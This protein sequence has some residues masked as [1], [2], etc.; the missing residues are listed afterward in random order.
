M[1]TFY[2]TSV[3]ALF[4]AL[5]SSL[6]SAQ[7]S[8][9][10]HHND[11]ARTGANL[12]ETALNTSNVNS[13]QFGK[14][15]SYPV[16]GE[17]YTQPLYLPAVTVPGKGV[18]NIVLVA[19]MNDSVYAFDADSN[20]GSN[21][22]PLWFTNF[23]N[24]AAGITPVPAE[25][26]Q[27][28]GNFNIHGPIGILS[29]PVVD[30]STGLVY[31]VARTK[32]NGSYFFRLHALS[33]ASGIEKSFSPVTITATVPGSGY[34][35]VGGMVTFNSFRSNQ[36]TALTLANG[37]VYVSFASLGDIDPYHG[38]LFGYSA[39][40]LQQMSVVNLT[41]NGTRGG[42][43]QSGNGEAVDAAGSV[44]L[45][46]GN[47][48]WDG[49]KNFGTSM[50]KFNPLNLAVADYFTPSDYQNENQ[51]D[52]DLGASGP[53]LIPNTNLIA[54]GGK[55]GILFVAPTG[56][57]GHLQS[58]KTTQVQSFQAAQG[59]IHGAPVYWQ[60]PQ[61]PLI[62]VWGERSHLD[63]FH[64]NGTTFD[65]VAVMQSSFPA[66][67]G[68]P[69]A[70]LSISANGSAPG[71]GILW[72][73]LPLNANAESQDVAGVLRA[74]DANN[75]SNE[76]WNSQLN[77]SRDSLGLFSKYSPPTVVNG[78]V[79]LS[80]FSN[81]LCVYG[82]FAPDFNLTSPTPTQGTLRGAAAQ[83]TIAMTPI[84][85][86][87]SAVQLSAQ[88]L[89]PGATATFKPASLTG[90]SQSTL[91]VS[92]TK[93]TPLGTYAINVTG[94]SGSTSHSMTVSLVVNAKVGVLTGGM[95]VPTSTQNLTAL[96]TADW[97][98]WGVHGTSPER[99][100]NVT[101]LISDF[102][103]VGS[104]PVSTYGDNAFG[105]SWTDGQ[106]DTA[107][108]N[109]K[110]GIYVTGA[111]NGFQITLPADTASR[112]ATI[113]AG[114][115]KANAIVTATLS[116]SSAPAYVNTALLNS[117]NS[118]S[119]AF[120]L[121]YQAGSA[122][123]TLTVTVVEAS[124]AID[125][126]G[127]VTVQ[128]VTLQAATAPTPDFTVSVSPST[129][130]L[131]AGATAAATVT[132]GSVGGFS[133]L[134]KLKLS[135]LPASVF[136]VFEPAALL[137]GKSLLGFKAS[138]GAPCGSYPLIIEGVSLG[139]VQHQASLTL[140]VAGTGNCGN[141]SATDSAGTSIQSNV[142]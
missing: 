112:T 14:L 66:P 43:W 77:A 59:H 124:P 116:D 139:G 47:G 127:N 135:G 6:A 67:D 87:T 84:N 51:S 61:G 73:S 88:N 99:K 64:F 41:P 133:G 120:T 26:V 79:Y 105:Y 126:S 62:Y 118:S 94:T 125:P 3:S 80:T 37:V 45:I 117:S 75:L 10:T 55:E 21:A 9:W 22:T 48:D 85:G 71:T 142:E 42:I 7:V 102:Q 18:H 115:Y 72:A 107:V 110:T 53:L 52:A 12:N 11:N 138:P 19:T 93:N 89:P 49:S 30:Q 76:L 23:T 27:Q 122:G 96:G 100:S 39:S 123:Q 44:Y 25:D 137:P 109:T 119:A 106:P 69:G 31:A 56:N 101:P 5:A 46:S 4:L 95:T 90:A 57:M 132:V 108:T 65:T 136:S 2:A 131:N 54:G 50:L 24:P 114:V 8:V 15:F 91:T 103:L 1:R 29:T 16:D 33:L 63:A 34:D 32:E 60:G 113:Y 81:Q 28:N 104:A 40:N 111:G 129:L 58:S 134:V 141:A 78:R 36:R 97:V 82:L 74:F 83:F 98:H 140:N 92:T 128:S 38:W 121:T 68:M 35:S 86:L 17:I 20:A 130:A 13:L 70:F